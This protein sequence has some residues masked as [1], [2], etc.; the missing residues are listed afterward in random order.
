MLIEIVAGLIL[1]FI[2]FRVIATIVCSYKGW[3]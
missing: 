2:L 1:A 3:S